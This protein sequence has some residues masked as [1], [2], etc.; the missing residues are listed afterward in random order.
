[1]KN[2][3]YFIKATLLIA[4]VMLLQSFQ[5]QIQAQQD[6]MFTHYM[7]NTLAVNPAYAGSRDALTIAGVSRMQW[8]GMDG[9]PVTQTLTVHSPVFGKSFGAGIN[10]LND[11]IGP[12]KTTNFY[13]DFSYR[14]Q[15]TKKSWLSFGLKSGANYLQSNLDGLR[16]IDQATD[17]AFTGNSNTKLLP[18]FGFGVYYSMKRFYAGISVPRII[19]YG[20]DGSS[21][22]KANDGFFVKRHYTFIAGS[23]V[24]LSSSLKFKPTTLV[25][26]VA[27]APVE[28]DLTA[29]FL[30]R[31][32]VWAGAMFRS[33]DAI[34]ALLGF[35][36]T[37]QLNVGYSYD[38]SLTKLRAYQGGSHEIMLTYDFMF[39]DQGR[40]KS[41]RYF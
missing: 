14:M 7:Y 5:N 20:I 1:M 36:F 41:P 27:G 17:Y 10:L 26:V 39:K 11:K 18:N 23:I 29:S 32:K 40:I 8:V 2:L 15:V 22:L 31:E 35:Q 25:K 37:P 38:Y 30:I 19:E 9:A 4:V 12:N 33:N 13:L 28:I 16:T 6:A 34:G 24:D 21:V 3:S